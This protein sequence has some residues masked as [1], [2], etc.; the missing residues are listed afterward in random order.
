MAEITPDRE[1]Q[2]QQMRA[3]A[4]EIFAASLANAS[5]ESAFARHVSCDRG[6]LRIC[7]DLHDLD[8]YSRVFV[9]SLGKAAHTM[10]GALEAQVGSR[11]EGIVASSV[12]PA[13]QVRG[14]RYFRGGH[15]TPTAESIHAADAIL[16]SL[17]SL[18]AAAL[19]LFML[20]GGGSSIVEEPMDDEISL[21]DLAATYRALVFS[22]API[23]EINAIRKHLSAVK[24]GRLAQTAYPAQQVSILVSDVPDATPDALASGPTMPDS[25]SIADCERIVAKY[26]L[27]EQFPKSVADLFRQHVI[28]E[29]PKS[30][31][32][33]FVR[34]RWWTVLSNRV[35]VE[36]ASAAATR[37]RF[38]VEVDN[39]CDDWDYEKAA[40]YLVERLRELRQSRPRVCLI[41]GGEVTVSV[42][43]GG[44]GGRN[45]QFALACAEKIAGEDITIL[46]AGTDGIDGNSPAAG[47]VVDGT[48]VERAGGVEPVR[49]ALAGFNVHPLLDALG[50][51]VVTGPTGN[52]LRD[53]RVLLA[54]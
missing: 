18:N 7:E 47:A 42:R 23:A 26:G 2:F 37:A 20:S 11:L 33:A 5:I 14:F 4:R 41:S 10:A 32:P 44:T 9:V 40:A 27:I 19:V 28:E 12:E 49:R 16:K 22:G 39:A 43:D 15:P 52:N 35:A 54:Y 25:T 29:T 13:N 1:H 46:S 36:E 50:D 45:Q 34:A 48:T 30:D 21:P 24:G 3:A 31:D 53:L 17:N 6:V 38:A 8:S 51:V